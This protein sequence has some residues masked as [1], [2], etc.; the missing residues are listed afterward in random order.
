MDRL[1]VLLSILCSFA[2]LT[3]SVLAVPSASTT[4]IPRDSTER[5]ANPSKPKITEIDPDCPR[6]HVS[7]AEDIVQAGREIAKDSSGFNEG[8]LEEARR[9]KDTRGRREN[10]LSRLSYRR[11]RGVDLSSHDI[12][13]DSG[14]ISARTV[15]Q[16]ENSAKD[17][18]GPA[19]LSVK[20]ISGDDIATILRR[21]IGSSRR[22]TSDPEDDIEVAEDRYRPQYPYQRQYPNQRYQANDRRDPYRNYLRYPVFPGRWISRG[23]ST[24]LSFV[25]E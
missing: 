16:A 14:V 10:G 6:I 7:H 18:R 11:E 2:I 1:D 17:Y 24:L 8:P 22:S 5:R 15:R 4:A 25:A 9:S 3:G 19:W 23:D 12:L 13:P 21:S 20:N